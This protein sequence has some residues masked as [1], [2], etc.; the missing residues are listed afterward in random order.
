M[1]STETPQLNP[2]GVPATSAM[3]DWSEHAI[4]YE[5]TKAANP[6]LPP[7][8]CRAY[9]ASLHQ[10]GPTRVIPFD[11]SEVL[12]IAT[13]ATSP[14]LLAGYVRIQAGE[15]IQTEA[16]AS[17][18]LFSVIR[19]SGSTQTP[20]GTVQWNKGDVLTFPAGG[21]FNH[22]AETDTALY[23]VHDGPLF[24]YLGAIPT[25]ARFR[26]TRYPWE[27]I[28][29]EIAKVNA[30][31]GATNRNRNAVILGNPDTTET[32]SLSHT[33]WSTVVYVEPGIVQRPHRHNSVAV[34][35]VVSAKPGAYTLVGKALDASGNIINPQRVDWEPGAAFITPPALWHAHYNESDE[36]AVIMAVQEASFY[37]HMRTLDIQFS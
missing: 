13:P 35:I 10:D 30:E 18:Q 33:V 12:G 26:P 2:H 1:Q 31:P 37:E 7:V 19:G 6:H 8:P 5:Y 16:Q 36:P 4:Y 3:T 11:C 32:M 9:P 22:Q 23:W 29:A 20:W 14:N 27:T 21:P 15:T 24:Q 17:A 34:D 25:Q 28:L